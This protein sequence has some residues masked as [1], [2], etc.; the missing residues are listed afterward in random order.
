M[1]IRRFGWVDTPAQRMTL[2]ISASL[3]FLTVL[4]IPAC[5]SGADKSAKREPTTRAA[6]TSTSAS[7]TTPPPTPA[8][9]PA[10]VGEWQR[11]QKCSELETVMNKAGL[12]HALLES[13]AG[14]GWIPGVTKVSQIRVPAHPCVGSVDRKH[15]HFFTPKGQFGS[16]DANGRQ[17]DDGH[18]QLAGD[19]FVID[20]VTFR[21]AITG[22]NTLSITPETPKCAPSCFEAGW[23]IAV[24]YPGYTWH[25][26]G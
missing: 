17:V 15:S 25:R 21:Y 16:R 19:A 14:D 5:S 22:N 18:Y 7:A 3:I 9:T 11:L 23:S 6:A 26:I 4:F 20:G 13:I 24:A 10:L 2:R 8:P 1:S 12:H